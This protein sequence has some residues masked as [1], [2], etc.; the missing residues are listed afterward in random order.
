MR[1]ALITGKV[2][3][4]ELTQDICQ[5][6]KTKPGAGWWAGFF[7]ALAALALGVGLVAYQIKV[8]IGTWGLNKTIGWAFDITNFV[9]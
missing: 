4:N 9:I 5:P 7:V 2:T 3:L 1:P 8:G 6:L